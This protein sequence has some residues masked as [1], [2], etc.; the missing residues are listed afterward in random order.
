MPW[1]VLAGW[2]G[3]EVADEDGHVCSAQE[4][5]GP[6]T[7]CVCSTVRGR[8]VQLRCPLL[9]SEPDMIRQSGQCPDR[10]PWP[11]LIAAAL[12][13]D[14]SVTRYGDSWGSV[15]GLWVHE[16]LS[17]GDS[18]IESDSTVIYLG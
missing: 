14:L 1:R 10:A 12:R 11:L 16:G 5:C 4:G 18:K 9:A 13:G 3:F 2:I 8:E 7:R 15:C 17:L 6:R